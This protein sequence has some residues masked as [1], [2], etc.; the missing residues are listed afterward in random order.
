MIHMNR[1]KTLGSPF[2]TATPLIVGVGASAGGLEAFDELLRTLPEAPEMAFVLVQHLEKGSETL[3]VE[4]LTKSTPYKVV[5]LAGRKKLKPGTVY[6]CPAWTLVQ[7]KNGFAT[8][9]ATEGHERPA[10]P[11][12]HF[13][14]SLAEDQGEFGIGVILSGTGSDGTLGLKAISDAGGTTLAQSPESAKF[15]SMPRSAAT[16]GV[17]DQ[18]L[19]PAEIA[20]ELTKYA[21]FIAE[22]VSD[23]RHQISSNKIREAIPQITKLLM[24]ATNHNFQHYK[25]NSLGRR[26]RRR[27]QVL[28]IANVENYVK[29]LAENVE[30][31]Q[32]LF[33]ELLISVTAFF[34][35]PDA[36]EVLAKTVMPKLFANRQSSDTLRIWVPGCA[37]GEEAFTLAILCREQMEKQESPP[38]VQIFAT[39]IDERALK[40]SRQGIYPVGIEE[41]I[42]EERLKKYFIK[43]GKKYQVVKEIR[44]L[45]FFSAHNL[46][47]D[48][49]F[50]RLDLV[51]CRNLLI[52]LGSHLQK[53]LIPLFH[54]ALRPSGFLM[55]GP[56][57]TISTH[58]ELFRPIDAKHRISQRKGTSVGATAALA[59]SKASEDDDA[60]IG[61]TI[62]PPASSETAVE[63]LM[64]VMQRIVLDEFAPKS[65][66]I[67]E[68]GKILCASADMQKYLTV[69]TGNFQNNII[70]LARTGLRIGLRATLQEAR[71]KRRQIVHDNLSVQVDGKLQRVLLTVQPMPRVGEDEELF[72]VVFQDSGLPLGRGENS[73]ISGDAIGLSDS[74]SDQSASNADS[75]IAHLER[76]LSTTRDDLERSIQELETSNEELKSSNEELLSLNEEMQSANEELETSK[77]EIQAAANAIQ[78]ANSDLENLLRSTQIATI[79]LDDNL[80]IRSFTPAATEIYGL[81]AT[82]IG[83]PLSQLMP[84]ADDLPPLPDPKSVGSDQSSEAAIQTRSGK[85]FVRRVLP[86]FSHRG[87]REGIV[88]TFNDVTELFDIRRRFESLVEASS[89]IVWVTDAAGRIIEDSPGWRAFT[90]QTLEQWFDNKWMEAIHPDDQETTKLA[91]AQSLKTGDPISYEYRIRHHSGAWKWTHVRAVAQ[92]AYDG[93]IRSWVGMNTDITDQK[94]RELSLAFLADLQHRLTALTTAAEITREASLRVAE[95]LQLSHFLMIEMDEQATTAKVVVD[96]SEGQWKSLIGVYELSK[97]V[98][99]DERRQL[100]AG[101]PMVVNDTASLLRKSLS[102]RNYSAYGVGAI[103]NVP[104]K[105]RL[106]FQFM[107]GAVKPTAYQWRDDEIELMRGLANMLRLKL[108]RAKAEA[109]LRD[110]ESHLRR[111]INNQLGLVGVIDTDGNLVE[112]DDRS[113]SIA[114]LNRDD[115]IGKHFAECPWWTYDESVSTQIREAME[116][117]FAGETVRF[118]V[119]LFATGNKRLM[120]DFMMAPV[121]D[122]DGNVT[123]LIPSGVDISERK[124][125][126]QQLA[127]NKDRLV[128][129]MSAARMG[130]Y[131]WEL[132]SDKFVS[133]DEYLSITGLT[134]D[135]ATGA[136]FLKLVYPDDVEANQQA[137]E[138]TINGKSD[139]DIQF[140]I[141]RPDGKVRWL[142]ARGKIVPADGVRPL[143]FV[144]MNWDITE[145]KEQ[146]QRVRESEERL[147]NAAEAAGF[148][149]VHADLIQGTVTYSDELLRLVGL[150]QDDADSSKPGSVPDWIH[151]EDR[152][153]Y[154][155][156][157]EE[158]MHLPE[159]ITNRLDH[160]IVRQDGEVRWVRL[161]AKPVYTGAGIHRKATQ[162]IGT[163]IDITQQREFEESLHQ[164]RQAAE[165]ANESKSEFLA[166]MSHEIR[167]PMTAIIGYAD[168][169]NRHLTDPDDL[170]CV[171]VIRNNGNFLLNIIND[172]LDISKVEAGKLEIGQRKV[173]VD[174]IVADVESLMSVRAA[175]KAIHFEVKFE[176]KIPETIISDDKRLKQ[177]L[178]NLVG[179][180]IKFTESG[181]VEL[182]IRCETDRQPAVLGFEVSDTGIGMS[183]RQMEKLFQPFSQA[184]SSVDRKYG[185][186]GLGLTIS[187]RLAEMLGGDITVDS[188]LGKGS[189]FS[190]S[191]NLQDVDAHSLI[192]PAMSTPLMAT[193]IDTNIE[194]R[195]ISGRILVVDDRREIR[196][197][198][199]HFIEDAGGTVLTGEH[200]QEA[201]DRIAEAE[202]AGTPFDVLVIDMQMPLMDGYEAAR[203]LRKMNFDKPIIALTAHAME[204]DRET[205]LAAGCS[206]YI[207]KPLDGPKFVELLSQ[208]LREKSTY[209]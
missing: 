199:Q 77:E 9:G 67:E 97:F 166:N 35:D 150:N 162:L 95:Y 140:R 31:P 69:G 159:G 169:L 209:E 56:S 152:E 58:G 39:D 102:N 176:T 196:F 171:K 143:R 134:K 202:A 125:A 122:D 177:V 37:T 13:L 88:V 42:S 120:I 149:T 26:I 168:I 94:N 84:L 12:D 164:A 106:Q 79:F 15:D 19:A 71:T 116:T 24:E 25:Q 114:G 186:T 99:D 178:L 127:E 86:Y 139:Y 180:A 46:I 54:Y 62:R 205:C 147:R 63:D 197:I 64:Q 119:G 192:E 17:A 157:F 49:P 27:M 75:I 76:E 132:E 32:A 43:R 115:V 104:S 146:E 161:Q 206:D 89:Q 144:G 108:D 55:L 155:S 28:K 184:N 142:A 112:V 118:D 74:N 91:W 136:D 45:V 8:I 110:S 203:R 34:R 44:E 14:Q 33:R 47:S 208:Y 16:T 175:E 72:M 83:R 156:H 181:S 174:Q 30:E 81:I 7:I 105:R 190:F 23:S 179:N 4:L 50:A 160:R 129:A 117:A 20:A 200:G 158:T 111:V 1:I 53:K 92:R 109:A 185:G 48:P 137:I 138:N 2:A 101:L 98:N 193:P 65:V 145:V 182:A 165:D 123:Y 60:P 187:K 85:W 103:L 5:K 151:A 59:N 36:F 22:T 124:L 78:V 52:Y 153:M 10:T 100:A 173:R 128:M 204:G 207:S 201:I 96:H 40:I 172:I 170:N 87:Q 51:S 21:R 68:D 131:D 18:V 188:T 194:Q 11:I 130:S 126:E 3:L 121:R 66:I 82:D 57:E 198:A 41:D 113:L 148:G 80:V 163:I 191:L 141:I 73:E 29:H 167:T 107:L 61:E 189:K 90:G 195:K 135:Q 133:D 154:A 183:R 38:E 93:A 6:V 70:K